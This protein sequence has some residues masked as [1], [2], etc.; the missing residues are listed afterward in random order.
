MRTTFYITLILFQTLFFRANAQYSTEEGNIIN[1]QFETTTKFWVGSSSWI[2]TRLDNGEYV[3]QTFSEARKTV[4][5]INLDANRNFEVSC[6]VKFVTGKDNL[7]YGIAWGLI[8]G[9]NHYFSFLLSSNGHYTIGEYNN[10]WINNK[11]WTES[12]VIEKNNFNHLAIKKIRNAITYYINGIEVY[13]QPFNLFMGNQIAMIVPPETKVRYDNFKVG[14]SNSDLVVP[15]P[16]LP[17]DLHI[18][19]ITFIDNDKTNRLDALENAQIK[20]T[21]ANRGKG[22]AYNVKVS[23]MEKNSVK[24]ISISTPSKINILKPGENQQ[25][26]IA[27][28][29]SKTLS[30]GKALLSIS[31][32]EH[33][34]FDSD[35]VQI[36]FSTQQFLEPKVIV[37]AH[38]FSSE[39]GGQ[40]RLGVSLNLRFV[41][42][43]IG[44]GIAHEVSCRV[45]LPE[46]IFPEDESFSNL[47]SLDPGEMKEVS[48]G[49]FG[50]K[51]YEQN[52]IPITLTLSERDGYASG[53]SIDLALDE[54]LT[55]TNKV[56]IKGQEVKA[57]DIK[58]A[59][60]TSDV[61][62][63]IPETSSKKENT[64][65]LIIGNEDYSSFQMGLAKEVNVDYAL[66]D[67]R[68]FKEYCSKTLGVPE[69][70]IKLLTNATAG[71]MNQGI[72]WLTNL[73]K[74]DNGKAEIIFYY[75]GHG[76]PEEAT[77]ESYLIPV[78]VSGYNVTQGIRLTD[79]YAKLNEYPAQKVTV[80]LDACFSGGGR[81]QGLVAM[82]GVKIKPKDNTINGNMV[83]FTS[84]S[85]EESSGV[86][87]EKQHGYMTYYL[88]KKLQET[89]GEATYSQLASYITESVKKETALTG[90]IQTPQVNFSMGIAGFWSGWKVK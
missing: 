32:S 3:F 78:D 30:T 76:L 1:E 11:P 47:G 33:N 74:V 6:M 43:N 85:G 38:H 87:R 69:K 63:N 9:G 42:Q 73:A 45:S 77:K 35:P 18:S 70:Q 79:V 16:K 62:A 10:Q 68:V 17:P 26:T 55:A 72:A 27:V 51:K 37:A 13:S 21:V 7:G 54:Q 2:D 24:G 39:S 23:A 56:E 19:D 66:N 8:E 60:L 20:F 31:A 49:F 12:L 84:S 41:V 82:K 14:Y 53:K 40:A 22:E 80:F 29:G 59:T 65:A 71:Q 34:G 44:Q 90:K 86:Y 36:E 57:V 48:F 15:K 75:S 81:N 52:S 64:Y 61:D 50:N 58:L 83:V 28:T 67:A 89:K 4:Q 46:N 5:T 25:I 88:L